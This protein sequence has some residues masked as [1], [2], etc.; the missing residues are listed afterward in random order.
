MDKDNI[1]DSGSSEESLSVSERRERRRKRR[2][3]DEGTDSNAEVGVKKS[4]KTRTQKEAMEERR[5]QSQ[6]IGENLPIIGSMVTYFRGVVSEIQKVTWPTPEEARRLTIIVIAVTI[7]VSIL[8]GLFDAAF[9]VW[10]REGVD[11]TGF[12]LFVGLPV[13]AIFGVLSW[14]YILRDET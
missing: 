2:Q 4:S 10:F 8:L 1:A 9:G 13:I 14:Y 3:A 11:D 5:K 6:V 12:F 7:F